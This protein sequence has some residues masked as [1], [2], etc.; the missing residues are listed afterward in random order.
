MNQKFVFDGSIS[1]DTAPN[2]G[3]T[4]VYDGQEHIVTDKKWEVAAQGRYAHSLNCIIHI[5]P[6]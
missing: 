3:D 4:I 6:I 1:A 5:E 2:I